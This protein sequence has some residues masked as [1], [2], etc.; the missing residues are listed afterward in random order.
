VFGVF[1]KP[2]QKNDFYTIFSLI[3]GLTFLKYLGQKYS[4][5][6]SVQR[7]IFGFEKLVESF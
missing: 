7:A 2:K 5:S 1:L 6:H 4:A 3:F